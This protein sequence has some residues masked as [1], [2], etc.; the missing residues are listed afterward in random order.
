MKYLKTIISKK[1]VMFV[2]FYKY[3]KFMDNFPPE[4]IKKISNYI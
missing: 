3:S 2:F 4:M 1:Q